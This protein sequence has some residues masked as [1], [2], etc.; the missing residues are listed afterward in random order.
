MRIHHLN[1]GTMCPV[2][3]TLVNGHGGLFSRARLVCHVLLIERADG[4]ALVDTGLGTGD[5]AA[6]RRLGRRW[7]WRSQPRLD[8]AETALAQVQALGYHADDVRDILLT[9]LDL[10]HAGG[11][12]DFP[13]ATVHVHRREHASAIEHTPAPSWP[14]RYI[15]SHVAHG[16]RWS[17][18]DDGGEPW[19]GFAGVR[20]LGDH[21]PDILLIPLPG[22][23]PGHSGIA[24]RSERGWLLHAG[25]AYF[26]HGQIATPPVP[27]PLG[28]RVFQR[29]AD[30]DRA[31]R[32]A[33]QARLVALNAAHSAEV[34]IFNGHDPV[35]YD[36]CAAASAR[37]TAA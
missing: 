10:D 5:V 29:R 26:F 24:V 27:A 30:T 16:P 4:L 22:H 8:P 12:P 32:V 19:F 33:N 3:A 35:D 23:T 21:E 6:P 34:T 28:L 15:D 2:G 13:S 20:A 31:Q 14:G 17:L 18:H 9:H 36:R 7:V 37:P 11:L 1:T 25:D